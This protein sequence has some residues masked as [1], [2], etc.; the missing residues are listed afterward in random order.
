MK[1]G[2]TSRYMLY[3]VLG[4]VLASAAVIAPAEYTV[5]LHY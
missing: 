1:T 3:V 2:K 4:V 5:L